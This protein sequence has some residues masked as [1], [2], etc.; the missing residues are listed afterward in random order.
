MGPTLRHKQTKSAT[1]DDLS[2]EKSIYDLTS[3]KR[4]SLWSRVSD[5]WVSI[6]SVWNATKH[7]N[8]LEKK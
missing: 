7:E 4:G 8:K 5:N 1:G 3:S 6:K 2:P